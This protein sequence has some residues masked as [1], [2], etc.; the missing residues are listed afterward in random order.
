MVVPPAKVNGFLF[1]KYCS[2]PCGFVCCLRK[3]TLNNKHMERCFLNLISCWC[4]AVCL[5]LLEMMKFLYL[6]CRTLLILCYQKHN[7][8]HRPLY[9]KDIKFRASVRFMCVKWNLHSKISTIVLRKSS[10]ISQNWTMCIHFMRTWWTFYTT[11]TIINWHW[12]NWTQLD[13]WLISKL[14]FYNSACFS[15]FADY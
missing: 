5:E 13:I 8:K 6:F 11:K 1:L 2:I 12:V 7:G 4:M 3:L 15:A 10:K 9:T 14:L